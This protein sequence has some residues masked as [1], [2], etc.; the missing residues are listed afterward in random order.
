[1]SPDCASRCDALSSMAVSGVVKIYAAATAALAAGLLAKPGIG[2]PI[3]LFD[4]DAH[5]C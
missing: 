5:E 1:M 3:I 4:L 2:A